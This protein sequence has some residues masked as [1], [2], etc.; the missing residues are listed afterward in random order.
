MTKFFVKK[1]SMICKKIPADQLVRGFVI[2]G[3]E[4]NVLD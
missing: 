4:C 3:G 2:S 1:T